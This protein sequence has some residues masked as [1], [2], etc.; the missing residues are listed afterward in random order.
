M[1]GPTM[2]RR[3]KG[4]TRPTSSPPPKSLRRAGITRSTIAFLSASDKLSARATEGQDQMV[5]TGRF[6]SVAA[7]LLLTA[8]AS[9]GMSVLAQPSPTTVEDKLRTVATRNGM[10]HILPAT[11][12]TTQWGWFDNAQPPVMTIASGDTVVMETLMHSQDRIVPGTTIEQI[13]KL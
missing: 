12:A 9:A 11:P 8:A 1:N 10:V 2:R 4:S 13:R 6:T 5:S 7:G 3:A